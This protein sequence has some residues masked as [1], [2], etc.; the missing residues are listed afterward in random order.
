VLISPSG[1]VIAA[2][3]DTNGNY[4]FTVA[5]SQ[6]SFRLIPSKDGFIFTPVDRTFAGLFDDQKDIEFV[7]SAG[8]Q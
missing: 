3:T 5:A 2:T 7:G 4:S 6:K 8:R 1:S